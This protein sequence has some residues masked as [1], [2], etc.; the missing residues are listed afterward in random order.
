M[1]NIKLKLNFL[2]ILFLYCTVATAESQTTEESQVTKERQSLFY[3]GIGSK[4]DS[5]IRYIKSVKLPWSLG[6]LQHQENSKT[7]WG[8]DIANEGTMLD[9]RHGMDDAMGRGLSYN[10]LAAT[11]LSDSSNWRFDLGI[12][13]GLR[14]TAVDCPES[15]IGYQCYADESPDYEYGFNYGANMGPWAP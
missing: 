7:S 5:S 13:L 10:L 9:S 15:Y 8:V 12:I 4:D 6:Y 3:V 2:I 1:K 11:N 14:E